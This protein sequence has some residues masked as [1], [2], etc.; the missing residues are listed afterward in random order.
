MLSGV[1]NHNG[2]SNTLAF[3]WGNDHYDL[4]RDSA[5]AAKAATVLR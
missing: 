1:D 5:V 4:V 2:D 3:F